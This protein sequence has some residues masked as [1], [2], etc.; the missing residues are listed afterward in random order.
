MGGISLKG[1][2]TTIFSNYRRDLPRG[3]YFKNLKENIKDDNSTNQQGSIPRLRIAHQ[4]KGNL[5]KEWYGRPIQCHDKCFNCDRQGHYTWDCGV[6]KRHMEANIA[7]S[8]KLT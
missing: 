3:Q 6:K 5:R 8:Y 1:D 4:N 7:S 2:E